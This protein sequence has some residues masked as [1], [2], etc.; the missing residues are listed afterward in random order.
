MPIGPVDLATLDPPYTASSSEYPYR[1]EICSIKL[2]DVATQK[3]RAT[4][5]G[6]TCDVW[7]VAFSPDGKTLASAGDK[8]M[9]IRLWDVDTATEKGVGYI[10]HEVLEP[11]RPTDALAYLALTGSDLWPGKGWNFVFGAGEPAATCGRLVHLP[12]RRS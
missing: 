5:K 10:L 6:H 3:E 7:S 1:G 8:D 11:Q 12:Q 4:L 2:W 9:T